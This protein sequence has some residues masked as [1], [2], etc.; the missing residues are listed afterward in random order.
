MS[1]ATE[2]L[3]CRPLIEVNNTSWIANSPEIWGNSDL[4]GFLK[5]HGAPEKT[6][7]AVKQMELTGT[8]MQ[9]I[10]NDPGWKE[11]ADEY[12]HLTNSIQ[13]LH[14]KAEFNKMARIKLQ[15]EETNNEG[16][17]MHERTIEIIEVMKSR[18]GDKGHILGERGIKIPAIPKPKGGN[19]MPQANEWKIFIQSLEMLFNLDQPELGV[20]LKR[21]FRDPE[22]EVDQLLRL[23]NTKEMRADALVGTQLYAEMP[24]VMQKMLPQQKDWQFQDQASAIKIVGSIGKHIMKKCSHQYLTK[25]Q[26]FTNRVTLTEPSQLKRE[27]EELETLL[28]DLEYQ[29]RPA[30]DTMLYAALMHAISGLRLNPNMMVPVTLAVK[31]CQDNHGESGS[32]LMDTLKNAVYQLETDPVYATIMANKQRA[33]KPGDQTGGAFQQTKPPKGQKIQRTSGLPCTNERDTGKCLVKGCQA[34]HGA[35]NGFSNEDCDSPAH[36][37]FG[38]CPSFSPQSPSPCKHKHKCH[39]LPW[40]GP[41]GLRELLEKARAKHPA[42]SWGPPPKSGGIEEHDDDPFI[43]EG[44]SE[45]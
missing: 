21:V 42:L 29:G 23:I 4:L 24:Y 17:G 39:T 27:L 5:H 6:L 28:D 30:A 43:S 38:V 10:V 35:T 45:T 8:S 44:V 26:L 34:I 19:N 18:G 14:I 7:Q 25:T 12:L 20:L 15:A 3:I 1:A 31:E 11:T 22:M 2:E 41:G 40:Q 37:E 32:K 16:K 36:K 13:A 33:N 9:E